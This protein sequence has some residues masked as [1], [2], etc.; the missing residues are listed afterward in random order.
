MHGRA[1]PA[2]RT[3][4]LAAGL[5]LTAAGLTTAGLTT[6]PAA[7]AARVDTL[8][9]TGERLEQGDSLVSP[10]GR[11]RL[12]L[13]TFGGLSLVDAGIG[14]Q[15]TNPYVVRTY[16]AENAPRD[17][18]H[19][20]LQGDGNLVGYDAA[21]QAVVSFG[22]QG[23]DATAVRVQDDRNVVFTGD[24]GRVVAHEATHRHDAVQ[25]TDFLL[26]GDSVVGQ[27]GGSRLLMQTDGNLV[28]YRGS[29]PLWSSRTQGNPGAF[30]VLQ[31]DGNLVV[32]TSAEQG[33]RVLWYSDT[34]APLSYPLRLVVEATEITVEF[35]DTGFPRH[36]LW[37]SGWLGDRL[38]AAQ[39]FAS[40][41]KRTSRGG[42]CRVFVNG[43]VAVFCGDGTS[44][45]LPA[46][47]PGLPEGAR[48][49]LRMQADGNLVA[50]RFRFETGR[51]PRVLFASGTS[52]PGSVMVVQD[53]ANLVV[54]RPDGRPAW[55]YL[56]GRTG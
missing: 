46:G 8:L 45:A 54:Y 10:D 19:V 17:V 26:P 23:S 41:E 35:D 11:T 3:A 33:R 22:T 15:T 18:D 6:A 42:G 34:Y 16:V 25:R 20:V 13:D 51:A 31:G 29:V 37:A 50:Y 14:A 12:Q 39:S 53:D 44:W 2:L 43:A 48:E 49:E 27:G 47:R 21:G 30:A 52:V 1:R 55:S 38:S 7:S 40:F 32:H 36:A 24:G 56:T 5:A 9:T 28:L 4:A